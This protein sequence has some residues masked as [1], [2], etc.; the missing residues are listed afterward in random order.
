[1]FI[2]GKK[3]GK[4]RVERQYLNEHLIHLGRSGRQTSEGKEYCIL[5]FPQTHINA[6]FLSEIDNLG[7]PLDDRF[8]VF[9]KKAEPLLTLPSLI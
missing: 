9:D 8:D 7:S 6:R 1:M 2:P 3:V 4:R 5:E